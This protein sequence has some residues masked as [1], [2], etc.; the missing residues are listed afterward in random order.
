M[1]V[2]VDALAT[3]NLSGR[4]VLL[5]HLERA[6]RAT[7]SRYRF[8]VLFHRGNADMRERLGD[9]VEWREC[10]A[11]TGHWLGR[12]AWQFVS[13]ARLVGETGADAV[14]TAS[15]TTLPGV[16]VPQVVYAMNPWPLVANLP[17]TPTGQLKAALQRHSYRRAMRDAD[18]FLFLSAHLRNLY[19]ASSER[20]ERYST[21]VYCGIDDETFVAAQ[22]PVRARSPHQIVCVS[23]MAPHKDLETLLLAVAAVRRSG[24]PAT[25]RLLGPW[26]DR[27]YRRNIDALIQRLG[28]QLAVSITGWV[29][30]PELRS[31][32]GE[33]RVF[34]L[35]SR[36][37][38][39]GIPAL[40]AQAFGTPVIGSTMSAMAEVCGAGGVFVAPGEVDQAAHLLG[41]LLT[42]GETWT[43]LSL[44]AALNAR[45]FTWEACTET[46]LAGLDRILR[47]AAPASAAEV[48]R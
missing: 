39:F 31:A 48:L 33:A 46:F 28:L 14:L 37:E 27:A 26:P 19:R 5:G 20:Q 3:T 35:L 40:E 4:H 41:T 10:P 9:R 38:S 30:A 47:A 34:A 44:A 8:V 15:G 24:T 21:I 43:S 42:N 45:R 16:R 12:R 18:G 6:A 17:R 23:A 7:P 32:Y 25:L 36:A 13:M 1:R 11:T 2:L 29:P 22:G